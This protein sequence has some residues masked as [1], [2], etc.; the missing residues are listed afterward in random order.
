MNELF[1]WN[2]QS[3]RITDPETS[4]EVLKNKNITIKWGTHRYSLLMEYAENPDGLIDEKAC[5]LAGIADLASPWRRCTDLRQGGYIQH[6][7]QKEKSSRGC[8]QMVCKITEKGLHMIRSMQE[9]EE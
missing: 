2:N 8:N 7:G 3:A 6:T 9:P 4:H 1:E 5:E